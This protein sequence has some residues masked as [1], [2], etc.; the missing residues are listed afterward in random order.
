M[1]D[2]ITVTFYNQSA[3]WEG[4]L[5]VC[6][7]ADTRFLERYSIFWESLRLPLILEGR[8]G[9]QVSVAWIFFL[10]YYFLVDNSLCDFLK[11][12]TGPE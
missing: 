2:L 3:S 11:W 10:E 8:K 9:V 7:F 1:K 6:L 5:I 4:R 12:N